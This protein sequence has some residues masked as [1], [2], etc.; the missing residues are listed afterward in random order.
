MASSETQ[1]SAKEGSCYV[2]QEQG[3]AAALGE[4]R[5]VRVATAEEQ[6]IID[7]AWATVRERDPGAFDRLRPSI[8]ALAN[9]LS[10]DFQRISPEVYF[11]LLFTLARQSDFGAEPDG[12]ITP[13][14]EHASGKFGTALG[15]VSKNN[16][17]DDRHERQLDNRLVDT[18]MPHVPELTA[19]QR[20]VLAAFDAGRCR[21][22]DFDLLQPVMMK[23]FSMLYP[24]PA[25]PNWAKISAEEVVEVTY[26]A[27]RSAYFTTAD[28]DAA[29]AHALEGVQPH[30]PNGVM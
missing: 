11:D 6:Q 3:N 27:A 18:M 9:A 15:S 4:M 10:P 12:R 22:P 21:H 16:P 2:N 19:Q 1:G 24:P 30:Q 28:R 5:S 14:L 26:C 29:F 23:V 7:G 8:V 17:I 20:I 25:S 13:T